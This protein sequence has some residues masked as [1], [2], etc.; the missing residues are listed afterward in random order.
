MATVTVRDLRNRS[1][2]VLNQVSQGDSLV[3]TRKGEPVAVISP[4]PR[5]RLTA[6]EIVA[7]RRHLPK[8]DYQAMRN[9]LDD[10]LD[11]DL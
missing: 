8:L 5:K 4:L 3:V 1:A 7:R 6:E 11:P 2:D 10:L 9:D